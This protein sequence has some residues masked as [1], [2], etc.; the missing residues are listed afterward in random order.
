[1]TLTPALKRRAKFMPTL[2]VENMSKGSI[3]QKSWQR[4]GY[5]LKA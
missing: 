2:R 5:T 3:C 4:T 1:M